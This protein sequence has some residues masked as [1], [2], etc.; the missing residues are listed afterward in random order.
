[1]TPVAFTPAVAAPAVRGASPVARRRNLVHG[2]ALALGPAISFGLGGCGDAGPSGESG[3][4]TGVTIDTI[5]DTVVVRTLS[6][7]VWGDV[8]TLA[9]EASIGELD[10]PREYLFGSISSIAV[11]DDR[12]VYVLDGQA[13]HVRVFDAAGTYVRTVGRPGEGPA[14]FTRAEAIALLPDG[15]LAVRDAGVKQIKVFGPGP[16]DVDQWRYSTT[17]AMSY[18]SKPLYT[19]AHGRTF[20]TD[21]G[22]WNPPDGFDPDQIIVLGP[23]GTHLDTMPVPWHEGEY[24]EPMLEAAGMSMP[25]PFS[26]YGHWAVAASGHFVSGFS[27]DYR[28][29]VAGDDGLLRI[30]R[31][32]QPPRVS[33]DERSYRRDLIL[34]EMRAV[35][36]GWRWQGPPIPDHKPYFSDLIPGRGGRIWVELITET[37]PVPNPN[38][39]P[40]RPGDSPVRWRSELRY[41]V[42][43]ADGTYLGSVDPPD[44]FSTR[45]TPAF[46]G[47]RVWAVTRDEL[48]VSRVVRFRIEVGEAPEGDA[49]LPLAAAPRGLP[50]R[51]RVQ[52][53]L[54]TWMDQMTNTPAF[55][56]P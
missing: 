1:M 12:S 56:L 54:Y 8:A 28:I 43:E 44:G 15:R 45:P 10:G 34:E 42:F 14:E 21:P 22:G 11:D 25:V 26:P 51:T 33:E 2:V 55:C 47:E 4:R 16:G 52:N 36:P 40:E 23:D 37:A 53:A 48:G 38:Y 50:S 7:G 9:P 5:G 18:T 32:A 6:G 29:D 3:D 46:D 20:Q 41:D 39:D 27:A 49:P 31:D 35:A 17:S 13:Q 19:D 24:A 30:E